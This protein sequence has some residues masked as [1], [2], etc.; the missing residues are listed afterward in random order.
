VSFCIFLVCLG[1]SY[2]FNK[3]ISYPIYIYIYIYS[4]FFI[5]NVISLKS[6]EGRNP[7]THKVYKSAHKKKKQKSKNLKTLQT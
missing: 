2:A 6:V 7:S 4:F 1:A 5:D 3:F